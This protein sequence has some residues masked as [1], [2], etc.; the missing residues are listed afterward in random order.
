MTQQRLLRIL[1][2]DDDDVFAML[3][4]ESIAEHEKLRE[5][6][7]IDRVND[8]DI[9]LEYILS[10]ARNGEAGTEAAR[11]DLILLDQRMPRMDG[12]EVLKKLKAKEETRAIP[13]CMLSTSNQPRHVAAC[14]SSGANFCMTKPSNLDQL[15]EQVGHL[16]FFFSNVVAIPDENYASA[17]VS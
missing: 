2:V 16:L 11:P 14:Y 13:I 5:Q 6:F 7:T 17:G 9:A 4:K 10:N 1:L 8:G 12:T 15:I 3:L